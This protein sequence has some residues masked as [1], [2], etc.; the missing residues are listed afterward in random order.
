MFHIE[1]DGVG[2]IGKFLSPYPVCTAGSYLGTS[3]LNGFF[4]GGAGVVYPIEMRT[5]SGANM[6]NLPKEASQMWF[7]KVLKGI[8][9][10]QEEHLIELITLNFEGCDI[11]MLGKIPSQSSNSFF[12]GFHVANKDHFKKS[13][14]PS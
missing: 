9:F 10:P 4:G 1:S 3:N 14:T 11:D 2:R 12:S 6:N 7:T 5:K 13:D 8:A